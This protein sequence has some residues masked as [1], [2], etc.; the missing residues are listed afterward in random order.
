MGFTLQVIWKN[1]LVA[2]SLVSYFSDATTGTNPGGPFA[3][4]IILISIFLLGLGGYFIIYSMGKTVRYTYVSLT[5]G[6]IAVVLEW[7][8]TV[9][10]LIKY[11]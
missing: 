2:G 9:I 8:L 10:F 3:A 6:L 5:A 7:S 11:S 4:Y 1:Y